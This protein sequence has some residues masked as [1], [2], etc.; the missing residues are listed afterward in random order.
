[1]GLLYIWFKCGTFSVFVWPGTLSFWVSGLGKW[2][3]KKDH[4]QESHWTKIA[5]RLISRSD[6]SLKIQNELNGHFA[7]MSFLPIRWEIFVHT[8]TAL[9]SLHK[10]FCCCH[11]FVIWVW[12]NQHFYWRSILYRNPPWDG[13]WSSFPALPSPRQRHASNHNVVLCQKF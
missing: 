6:F 13:A 4:S 8:T 2:A 9:M 3:G 5:Q 7:A 1:M 11:L 10:K 12:T